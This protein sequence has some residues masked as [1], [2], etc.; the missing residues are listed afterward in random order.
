MAPDPD[1]YVMHAPLAEFGLTNETN[2]E[3]YCRA[4]RFVATA[5]NTKQTTL[6]TE[7]GTTD[8]T[9]R[10]IVHQV[11]PEHGTTAIPHFFFLPA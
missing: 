9:T 11:E 1:P 3:H 7:A 4:P 5:Q 2:S 10:L 6:F 8:S